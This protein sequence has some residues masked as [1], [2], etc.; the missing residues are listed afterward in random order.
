MR[1][2]KAAAVESE[3]HGMFLELPGAAAWNN[4][5]ANIMPAHVYICCGICALH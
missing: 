4:A 5:E 1:P 2:S 3:Q